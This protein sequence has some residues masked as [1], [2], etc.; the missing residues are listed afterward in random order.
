MHASKRPYIGVTGVEKPDEAEELIRISSERGSGMHMAML[1]AQTSYRTIMEVTE[2][3]S[4]IT[5]EA[6]TEL[7]RKVKSIGNNDVMLSFHYMT[8]PLNQIDTNI[9][10]KVKALVEMP[11]SEQVSYLIDNIY[12]DYASSNHNFKIGLQINCKWPNPEEVRK[13]KIR[14]PLAEVVLQVSDFAALPSKLQAYS[15]VDYILIDTSRGSGAA[16]DP[17]ESAQI[18]NTIRLLTSGGIV[19]AGGISDTNVSSVVGRLRGITGSNL[20][21]ID[22]QDK[23][24]GNNGLDMSKASGYMRRARDSLSG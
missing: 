23:L 9:Q 21:S 22:A 17:F 18:A 8:K 12:K 5:K 4:N 24:R 1:G 13:I 10:N 6:A 15:S 2:N 11:L 7:Y 20:F 19:F 16:F 14:Y 3:T